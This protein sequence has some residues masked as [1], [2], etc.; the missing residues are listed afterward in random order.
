MGSARPLSQAVSSRLRKRALSVGPGGLALAAGVGEAPWDAPP[1]VASAFSGP[2]VDG[3]L[4]GFLALGTGDFQARARFS[5]S[6]LAMVGSEEGTVPASVSK[7][8]VTR[9]HSSGGYWGCPMLTQLAAYTV[10][11]LQAQQVRVD[12]RQLA[13]RQ[14]LQHA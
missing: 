13:Q 11:P 2:G 1:A 7:S 8:P 12:V 4:P 10:T 9:S 3:F 14:Q 5:G 6:S